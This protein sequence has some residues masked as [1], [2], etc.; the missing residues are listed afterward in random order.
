VFAVLPIARTVAAA[1]ADDFHGSAGRQLQC[2]LPV[3]GHDCGAMGH[4]VV[5]AADEGMAPDV[6][7]GAP[8]SCAK[9]PG[10]KSAFGQP[11]FGVAAGGAMVRV[12]EPVLGP[13]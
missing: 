6:G 11:E 12:E 9:E 7:D 5:A 2:G 3:A 10:G 4:P 13:S 1:A 8:P